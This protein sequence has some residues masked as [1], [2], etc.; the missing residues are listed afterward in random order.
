MIEQFLTHIASDTVLT[1]CTLVMLVLFAIDFYGL[2]CRLAG[3]K[4]KR[5]IDFK[6]PIVSIGVFGT[7]Y[8]ILLGLYNFDSHN[9]NTSVPLLLEGLKFAFATSVAGM[10]LSL[11]LGIIEK[12]C[13]ENSED[14][15]LLYGIYCK[16]DEMSTNM[17]SL[18]ETLKSPSE[19]VNQFSEMKD[20]LHVQMEKVNVSLDKALEQLARGASKEL[21]RAL[22]NIIADFNNNLKEQF[23]DNFQEL[24]QAC[25]KLLEW[26][27]NYRNHVESA[28]GHLAQILIAMDKAAKDATTLVNAH[29]ETKEICEGVSGLIQTYDLQVQTLASYLESCKQLGSEAKEFLA[30]TEHAL[31]RSSEN[32][33]NFSQTIETSVRAQSTSLATLTEEINQQLPEA[34]GELER[35]LTEL[36]RQFAGD[37]RSLFE[38]VTDRRR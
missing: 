4:T 34:L 2:A 30:T 35:V 19:L 5:H 28:E 24:N 9:I 26:Q 22:E 3:S 13:G 14:N 23:G 8:G 10:F 18:T 16:M 38:F 27:R 25:F 1:I 12:F 37:Y 36:T 7:F 20:F 11:L 17:T 6:S 29:Q 32:M 21:I 31:V 15:E 33:N